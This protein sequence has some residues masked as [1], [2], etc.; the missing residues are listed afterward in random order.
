[1][2]RLLTNCP[3][4]FT[5]SRL[6]AT[7]PLE[8]P[9]EDEW[10]LTLSSLAEAFPSWDLFWRGV[11][12]LEMVEES[13]TRVSEDS[14]LLQHE[15]SDIFGGFWR[16]AEVIVEAFEELVLVEALDEARDGAGLDSTRLLLLTVRTLLRLLPRLISTTSMEGGRTAFGMILDM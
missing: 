12:L 5:A 16:E 10:T 3:S 13:D 1:M 6:L 7:L 15:L 11:L 4:L 2:E 8:V 14:E 9:F